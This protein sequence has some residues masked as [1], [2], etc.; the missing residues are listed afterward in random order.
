MRKS[1]LDSPPLR[2]LQTV[3]LIMLLTLPLHVVWSQSDSLGRSL[4]RHTLHAS[5]AGNGLYPTLGYDYRW[6]VGRNFMSV[7]IGAFYFPIG[8]R[9]LEY[10]VNALTIIPLQCS[11]A[12]HLGGSWAFETGIGLTYSKGASARSTNSLVTPELMGLEIYSEAVHLLLKPASIRIQNSKGGFFLRAYGLVVYKWIEMN[13]DMRKY[14]AQPE[15]DPKW[16]LHTEKIFGWF[17]LDLGYTFKM[18]K[19]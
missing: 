17:G 1:H 14:L 8:T 5:L 9:D 18:H 2:S 12:L 16:D 10:P 13:P 15:T 11:H 19:K 6:P 7:G 4:A 3:M